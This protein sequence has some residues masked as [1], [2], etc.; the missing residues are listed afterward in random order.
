MI[1]K[2]LIYESFAADDIDHAISMVIEESGLPP[3]QG[4]YDL[5]A[6]ILKTGSGPDKP[7]RD[8]KNAVSRLIALKDFHGFQISNR[9]KLP[10]PRNPWNNG[11][12]VDLAAGINSGHWSWDSMNSGVDYHLIDSSPLVAG[13]LREL[14]RL[15]RQAGIAEA[16]RIHVVEQ[17]VM[18]LQ[19]PN[20]QLGAIRAKNVTLYVPGSVKQIEEMVGWLAP[21]GQLILPTDP[22]PPH[23]LTL[24]EDFT[25]LAQRLLSQGWDLDFEVGEQMIH[26]LDYAALTKPGDFSPKGKTWADLVNA[27]ITDNA[28]IIR[29]YQPEM[30]GAI[31]QMT[32]LFQAPL[33]RP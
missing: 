31:E 27:F 20:Q 21:G 25:R 29:R 13:Y 17:D 6:S 11:P 4:S 19:K 14:Y 28:A 24:I 33:S 2:L 1:T 3:Y 26:K 12:Y 15:G 16:D 8:L 10:Y 23:R 7:A 30:A 9:E 5:L 32:E 18:T 22:T